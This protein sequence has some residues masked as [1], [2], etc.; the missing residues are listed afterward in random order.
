MKFKIGF[1][2]YEEEKKEDLQLAKFTESTPVKS[3]VQVQFPSKGR[4][5]A[6]YNDKFDLHVGDIVFVDGKLEGIQGIVTEVSRSFKIKLSDYK[7]VIAVADTTVKGELINDNQILMNRINC[8][9]NTL[10][11]VLCICYYQRKLEDLYKTI[12][13]TKEAKKIIDLETRGKSGIEKLAFIL[14]DNISVKSQL[15]TIIKKHPLVVFK[16]ETLS[17]VFGNSECFKNDLLRHSKRLRWQI[18]RIYRYRCMAVHDGDLKYHFSSLNNIL[19]NLHYYVDELFN[20]IFAKREE[21]I[22]DLD[23]ILTC[24][25]VK[26]T[27]IIKTLSNTN[28]SDQDF[29]N[30]LFG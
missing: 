20:Y 10:C 9:S 15:C 12:M 26:E 13:L 24:A 23:A 4:S 3:V 17:I 21:K 27:S 14:K 28:L 11:S 1:K 2:G 7:R 6:Y 16:I 5:L 25:R 19:E 8:I 22:F 30:I 29:A 18:M